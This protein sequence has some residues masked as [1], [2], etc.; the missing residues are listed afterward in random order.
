[1]C[2][3]GNSGAWGLAID[4]VTNNIWVIDYDE[5]SGIALVQIG[6]VGRGQEAATVPTLNQYGLAFLALLLLGV[7]LVGFRYT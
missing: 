3:T 5:P 7:G 6:E 4:P 2:A 1:V